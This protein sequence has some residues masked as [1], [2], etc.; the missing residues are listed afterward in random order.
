VGVLILNAWLTAEVIVEA[1]ISNVVGFH[2]DQE[3]VSAGNAEKPFGGMVNPQFET[4]RSY[5]RNLQARQNYLTFFEKLRYEE[6]TNTVWVAFLNQMNKSY[7]VDHL[8]FTTTYEGPLVI[9]GLDNDWD[10]D[11][12]NCNNVN[13]LPYDE[14]LP[15]LYNQNQEPPDK[16]HYML[17]LQ[18]NMLKATLHTA[19]YS[20]RIGALL[21]C[22]GSSD[23]LFQLNY[24]G[25]QLE[26]GIQKP[27]NGFDVIAQQVMIVKAFNC[28]W[29][30]FFPLNA[31]DTIVGIYNA[32]GSD[33]FDRLNIIVNGEG[34]TV[35]F[36]IRVYPDINIGKTDLARD[37]FLTMGWAWYYIIMLIAGIFVVFVHQRFD[38]NKPP[39]PDQMLQ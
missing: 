34:S 10:M 18:M 28:T 3:G 11:V 4:E 23:S 24:S 27:V 29:A 35:P 21:G 16:A 6:S 36:K 2:T 9:D 14:F 7:G 25:T 19:G 32:Y 31:Y 30:S 8:L 38:K 5:E 33:F 22:M 39:Q 37:V 13:T 1:N 15:M 20:D 17:Y 12:F 26:D